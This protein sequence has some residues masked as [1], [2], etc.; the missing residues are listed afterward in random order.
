MNVYID[1]QASAFIQEVIPL[2]GSSRPSVSKCITNSHAPLVEARLAGEGTAKHNSSKSLIATYVG[3]QL[4]YQSHEIKQQGD[5]HTL[6]IAMPFV[7]TIRKDSDSGIIMTQL[8]SLV[9]GVLS[10]PNN[11]RFRAAQWVDRDLPSQGIDDY[12]VYGRPEGHEASLGH[13]SVSNRG[14]FSTEGHRPM[15]I[16]KRTDNAETWLCGDRKDSVYLAAGGP[17][18]TDHD[19]RQN[20]FPGLE[21]TTVPVALCHVLDNYERAFADMT[22]YRRQMRRKHQDNN[23]WWDDIGLWEPLLSHLIETGLSPGLW[24][25][26]EVIGVRS[27]VANQLPNEAFF[28]RNGQRIIEKG[29]YQ[30]P[31][32]IVQILGSGQLDH[33]RA[34]LHWVGELYDRF[35]NLVIENC[36]S[37]AQRM[38]HAMLAVHT[39][40]STSDQQDPDS[41]GAIAAALPTTMTPEQGA[42]WAYPQPEWHDETNAMTVVNSLGRI[43]LSGR[44]DI[45]KPHQFGLIKQGMDIYRIL[46]PRTSSLAR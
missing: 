41:Y 8:S 34:Y 26:P 44:L 11:S 7:C 31:I 3:P 45:L 33:N 20:L 18:E 22:Q 37:S 9:L 39:L 32:S 16:L 29:R 38:D 19:W 12:G 24:I 30:A 14:T 4:Q 13:Y 17:V 35:T 23:R 28:R 46:A 25:E 36:S 5:T 21:I 6:D 10:G 1:E 2:P 15:G 42:I 43:H 40:Q 27:I